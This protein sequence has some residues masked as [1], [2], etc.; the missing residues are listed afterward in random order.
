MDSH[1]TKG[2][3][4]GRSGQYNESD[5]REWRFAKWQIK[6]WS[7][8]VSSRSPTGSVGGIGWT[9]YRAGGFRS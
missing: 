6:L 8:P 9:G 7:T 3:R 5:V 1:G 2:S 4:T